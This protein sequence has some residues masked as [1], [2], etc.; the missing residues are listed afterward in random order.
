MNDSSWRIVRR[1]SAGP[2]DI[3]IGAAMVIHVL[4]QPLEAAKIYS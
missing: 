1:K 4:I 3:A 2:V